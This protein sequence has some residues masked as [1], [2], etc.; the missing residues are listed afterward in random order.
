ME[1]TAL[2]LVIDVSNLCYRLLYAIQRNQETEKALRALPAVFLRHVKILA[3][4]F[5]TDNVAFCMDANLRDGC[6]ERQKSFPSYKQGRVGKIEI[7]PVIE[8]IVHRLLV[9]LGCRN[10]FAQDGMEADDLMGVIAHNVAAQRQLILVSSDKDL[11]QL[12]GENVSVFDGTSEMTEE[13]FRKHYGIEPWNWRQVK[14][15]IGCKTD[16]VPGIKGI[17]LKTSL[18]FLKG[19]LSKDSATHR[20][21]MAGRWLMTK[22]E[23]LVHL[24][25]R[26]TKPIML[27]KDH[28]QWRTLPK[29]QLLFRST[30]EDS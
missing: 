13:R 20:K 22:N 2:W 10:V 24:P 9:G 5:D 3:E 4:R 12:I 1:T 17:G 25:H 11:Y 8:Q 21:I 18:L 19:E 15:M 30:E 7:Y 23:E 29:R 16:N 14:C 28:V 6:Y 26:L 27:R